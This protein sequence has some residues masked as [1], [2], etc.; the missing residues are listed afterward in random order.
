MKQSKIFYTLIIL[1]FVTGVTT[2]LI[3]NRVWMAILA[4]V[5]FALLAAAVFTLTPA[6]HKLVARHLWNKYWTDAEWE[7]ADTV[8][9]YCAEYNIT[10]EVYGYFYTGNG[11]VTAGEKEIDH[12]ACVCPDG[13]TVNIL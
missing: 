7:H 2:F 11:Y 8:D 4:L 3:D 12:I 5:Q 6:Y 13:S 10:L 1:S 9:Q